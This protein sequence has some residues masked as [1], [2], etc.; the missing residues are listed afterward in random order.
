MSPWLAK[1][2]VGHA[3]QPS[4]HADVDHREP[5]QVQAGCGRAFAGA[6]GAYR[7]GRP[8]V[9]PPLRCRQAPFT[10]STNSTGRARRL[11]FI[12]LVERRH[13][14]QTLVPVGGHTSTRSVSRETRLVP[15]VKLGLNK[16]FVSD[17]CRRPMCV[18]GT[19]SD[20]PAQHHFEASRCWRVWPLRL[21]AP[22]VL[23]RQ[24]IF[25]RTINLNAIS[26]SCSLKS[27]ASAAMPN[28]MA[29]S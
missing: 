20:C 16:L 5:P 28:S 19:S 13:S 27:R 21:I 15:H 25:P 9:D 10:G 12:A 26:A 14:H 11:A 22:L 6:F 29:R 3:R 17:I 8:D 18:S 4:G 1:G 2:A 23:D 7:A 24:G